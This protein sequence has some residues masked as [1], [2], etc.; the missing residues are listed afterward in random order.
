MFAEIDP[1]KKT[2]LAVADWRTAF[3]TFNERDH[4]MVELKNFLQVQ[5]A[6]SSS[7]FFFFLSFGPPGTQ[8]AIN[9][10]TF[11]EA[12]Q[13][14]IASRTLKDYQIRQMFERVAQGKKQ[15]GE[16]EFNEE[17]ANIKFTGKQLINSVRRVGVG[18]AGEEKAKIQ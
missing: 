12:A 3:Q 4:L 1:H 10:K 7:A 15:F 6:N 2:Y 17:F 8:H 18:V 11:S 5:F 14:L 16:K 13:S 9:Y